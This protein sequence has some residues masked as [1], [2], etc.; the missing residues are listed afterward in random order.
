MIGLGDRYPFLF[1]PYEEKHIWLHEV[2]AY[3]DYVYASERR[4]YTQKLE[5]VWNGLEVY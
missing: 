4:L 2:Q 1:D 5:E 3:D